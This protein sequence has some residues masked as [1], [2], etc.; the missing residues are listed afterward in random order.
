M[1]SCCEKKILS[2]Y[3]NNIKEIYV[4]LKPCELCVR[5]ID[6]NNNPKIIH[7]INQKC[8]LEHLNAYDRLANDIFNGKIINISSYFK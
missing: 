1:F 2:K 3:P 8:S 5:A 6:A 4:K 7:G